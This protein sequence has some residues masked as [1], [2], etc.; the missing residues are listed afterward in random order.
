M[1]KE[2]IKLLIEHPEDVKKTINHLYLQKYS[3][4]K[5]QK[6]TI[7]HFKALGK[8]YNSDKFVD[9]YSQFILDTLHICG[10]ESVHKIMK[11]C[12]LT[13]DKNNFSDICKQKNQI[14]EITNGVYLKTYSP[15]K[16]KI[17]HIQKLCN[18]LLDCNLVKI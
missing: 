9:N 15:T 17:T 6:K 12:Y 14:R 5:K 11:D 7:F 2:L 3:K 1:E 16:V 4:K 18:Q 13:N 8:E 10:Y